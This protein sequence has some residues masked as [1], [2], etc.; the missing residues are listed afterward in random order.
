MSIGKK[1]T[2]VIDVTDVKY[3]PVP[4]TQIAG[5]QVEICF[6]ASGIAEKTV[7]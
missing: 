1:A 7:V 2:F 6:P 3:R 5:I 4:L